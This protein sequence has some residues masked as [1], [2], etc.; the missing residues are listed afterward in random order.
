MTTDFLQNDIYPYP[1]VH[2]HAVENRRYGHNGHGF[3]VGEDSCVLQSCVKEELAHVLETSHDEIILIDS[4]GIYSDFA[5]S[6]KARLITFG[7]NKEHYINPFYLVMDKEKEWE[8][9]CE[10]TDFILALCES[11]ASYSAGFTIMQKT[12]LE[13][14]I[15]KVYTPF[16]QSYDIS[17]HTYN[18]DL[19]P[20]FDDFITVLEMQKSVSIKQIVHLLKTYKHEIYHVLSAEIAGDCSSPFVVYNLAIVPDSLKLAVILTIIDKHWNNKKREH[21]DYTWVYLDEI[22]QLFSKPF[23]ANYFRKYYTN[24]SQTRWIITGVTQ[25]AELFFENTIARK[26]LKASNYVILFVPSKHL[27]SRLLKLI[28]ASSTIQH[29]R[30]EDRNLGFLYNKVNILSFHI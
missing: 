7:K 26:L 16:I 28:S 11:F 23:A 21:I 3:I 30:K 14:C 17:T 27:R 25:N 18:Y 2:I 20:T 29:I 15:K 19:L 8:Q 1:S 4:T 24:T 9:L 5:F 10:K 6:H 13:Y 22:H 12:V